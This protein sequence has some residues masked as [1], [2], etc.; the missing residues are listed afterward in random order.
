MVILIPLGVFVRQIQ[1]VRRGTRR[2]FKAGLLL[3]SYSIL[4]VLAYVVM[5]IILVGVEEYT[6]FSVI[7]EGMARTLLPVITIGL[8][9]VL[10]L[11]V[12]F[13]IASWFLRAHGDAA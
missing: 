7:S 3:F 2:K 5:F 4:P 13:A 6:K 9:E 1:Q 11:T 8:A 12:I 10:L